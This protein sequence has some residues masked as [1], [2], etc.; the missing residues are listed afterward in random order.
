MLLQFAK[1]G[2]TKF[3]WVMSMFAAWQAQALPSDLDANF[4][5]AGVFSRNTASGSANTFDSAESIAVDARGRIWIAALCPQNST[6][7]VNTCLLRLSPSGLLDTSFGSQGAIVTP[8]VGEFSY[9]NGGPQVALQTNGQLILAAQCASASQQRNV[10]V[11]RYLDNGALDT[12][13]GSGGVISIDMG[14]LG[15]YDEVAALVIDGVD[16]IT[17]GGSAASARRA[18]PHPA[19]ST[20]TTGMAGAP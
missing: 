15:L 9:F 18:S 19:R 6:N 16:R 2:V 3:A 8:H 11:S 5:T 7:T 10:C 20:P 1:R 13:F 17:V 14:G 4:A 12:S